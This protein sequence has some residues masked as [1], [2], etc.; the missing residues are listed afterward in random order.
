MIG[1]RTDPQLGLLL[2][3]LPVVWPLSHVRLF[4]DP[5]DLSATNLLHGIS[6]GKNAGSEFAISFSEG[7]PDQI[8]NLHLLRG[9]C[10]SRKSHVSLEWL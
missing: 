2:P 4:C 9:G 5:V 10:D 8:L 6:P 3:R 1:V 7:L